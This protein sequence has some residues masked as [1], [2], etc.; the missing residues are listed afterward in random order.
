MN[1][2]I[3]NATVPTD[4]VAALQKFS[5]QGYILMALPAGRVEVGDYLV[6][7]FCGF[8]AD[9]STNRTRT[10]RCEKV[11]A[12]G[13]VQG[14]GPRLS[15]QTIAVENNPKIQQYQDN[16]DLLILTKREPL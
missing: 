2:P 15:Q 12:T 8:E 11:V 3:A 16:P 10:V 4:L 14:S 9:D 1:Q 5:D 13:Y 7:Y 6:S